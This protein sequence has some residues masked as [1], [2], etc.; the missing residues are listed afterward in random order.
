MGPIVFGR[1]AG[2]RAL[3]AQSQGWG[4]D[5]DPGPSG[6]KGLRDP[7]HNVGG[8]PSVSGP[9]VRDRSWVEKKRIVGTTYVRRPC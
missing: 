2:N 9:L 3:E 7:D 1:S 8:A 4:P 6:V 5:T